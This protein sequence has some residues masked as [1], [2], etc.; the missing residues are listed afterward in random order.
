V[1]VVQLDMGFRGFACM[2][3]GV[4][5]MAM[6]QMRVMG[7]RF[8][9]AIRD[10]R[11]GFAVMLGG[12]FVMFGGVLVVIGGVLGV[13]HGRLPFFA[14]SCG[15]GSIASSCDRSTTGSIKAK[16]VKARSPHLLLW[17]LM[18][19]RADVVLVELGHFPS[20]AR[21]RAAIEARLVSVDGIPLVKPSEGID[22]GALIQAQDPHPWVSRGGVKLE[23]A[24]EAF[25]LEP[26]GL[27]VLD[28]GA[29]TGGFT[30]VMLARGARRVY[31]I[32]VGRSQLDA[33][34]RDNDR[35][36]V[37]EGLD[38]RKLTND[39]FDTPP[40]AIV[41][42]VS[43]IS[44]R[45]ILPHVLPL[46]AARAWLVALIKPQFEAGRKN[47]V[48]GAVKDPAIHSQ[49]CEAVRACAEALGWSSL[50]IIP[51]PITGGDGAKEFLFGARRG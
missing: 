39:L 18:R 28:I 45:L 17:A 27:D 50:G 8:V 49:V 38:A 21:A 11:G 7:A 15:R 43:F 6:G 5:V 29:S 1:L 42:D 14:A 16:L 22:P 44:L 37:R 46:A 2:M 23:A 40:A 32:D 13:S 4:L 10:M 47:V 48:K 34:L 33:R 25:D 30:D 19:K 51:S 12:V 35:V 31:A 20:R 3:F 9:V 24:L 26:R 41:C 36:V